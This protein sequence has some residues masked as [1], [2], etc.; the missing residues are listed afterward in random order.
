MC[1]RDLGTGQ[2]GQGTWSL[3]GKAVCVMS[4]GSSGGGNVAQ[5]EALTHAS[6]GVH[7][8][9]CINLGMVVAAYNPSTWED[10]GGI[11]S[12]RSFDSLRPALATRGLFRN[13]SQQSFTNSGAVSAKHR[14]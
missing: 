3:R 10:G 6:A 4:Q 5:L 11:R 8:H 7:P 12:S 1:E 2:Q 14:H 9:H 13:K